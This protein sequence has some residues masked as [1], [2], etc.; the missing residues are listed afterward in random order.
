MIAVN[1]KP[2]VAAEWFSDGVRFWKVDGDIVVHI[3]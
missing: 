1:V 3:D 2:P